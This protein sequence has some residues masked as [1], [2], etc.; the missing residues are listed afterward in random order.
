MNR[1][2]SSLLIGFILVTCVAHAE[3]PKWKAME[4]FCLP[5][6][7]IGGQVYKP[8]VA[9]IKIEYRYA[10]RDEFYR[11]NASVKHPGVGPADITQQLIFL[12]FRYGLIDRLDI[13][14][15]LPLLFMDIKV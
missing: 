13:R 15:Q 8:G 11:G 4:P 1:I 14:A 9:A 5:D 10:K 7:S 3:E 12:G 2:A 6:F